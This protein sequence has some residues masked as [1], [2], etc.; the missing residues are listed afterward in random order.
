M[1]D[2]NQ[3]GIT[4]EENGAEET[5]KG[6]PVVTEEDEAN[7]AAF[8]MKKKAKDGTWV[9]AAP[10][11]ISGKNLEAAKVE[12]TVG[13]TS[14]L[15]PEM[16]KEE[17][18]DGET[19]ELEPESSGAAPTEELRQR[20]TVFENTD[21]DEADDDEEDAVPVKKRGMGKRIA[22]VVAGV[23]VVAVVAFSAY[24]YTYG[25]IFPG[26]KV[27][28]EYKLSGMTQSEAQAYIA[29]EVQD[30]VF[31]KSITLTGKD[32]VNDE[33]K[34]YEI[35]LSDVAEAV[36]SEASAEQAY[37]MGRE[38]GYFQR[39]STVLG[40]IFSGRDIS[41]NATLKDGAVENEVSEITED[42]TYDPT[43]PS[44]EVDKENKE[45]NIDT[46]KQGVG[47]DADQVISDM[48]AQAQNVVLDA[49]T[50]ETYAIDQDKPDAAAIAEDV[51]TEPQNATVDKE[52]GK[53][54]IE[55]VD[56]IEVAESDIAA[57]LGDA[58]EQ[59]YSIPIELTEATIKKA[60]LEKVLFQDTLASSTTYYNSGLSGRTT[61]VRLA[62]NAVDETILNPGEE[63]SYNDTVGERTAARGYRAATIFSDGEEVSG[64]GG[65]VCQVSS[66]IYMA[67]L[68]ADLEVTERYCHQFQVSY[69]PVSQDAAVYWGS[70]D[71]KFVNNT[72]YPVKIVTSVG[73]GS[74]TVS[75]IGT[76]TEDKEI[77]FSSKTYYS[78]NYKYATLYKSV[79]KNGETTTT[80]E[81]SSAY[82]L[83]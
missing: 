55:A 37:K 5:T 68:R 23:A 81:N 21:D 50:I 47:F 16:R 80:K 59:S 6:F 39:V 76:K 14:E 62:A 15:T 1:K 45:L 64:L 32:V 66:T 36:D 25:K 27:A 57:A 44:W 83:S 40:C 10:V 53:T 28:G 42:L 41:L 71:F 48:T 35:K 61:N 22:A 63:F 75:V 8:E 20:A 31:D 11:S 7:A 9:A 54:V 29:G 4:P 49:Y 26:V 34:T 60:D 3:P 19:E 38:G 17:P 67:I 77:S 82:L 58:S 73:G 46:G 2:N 13:E 52:D 72:D 18:E 30:N 70:K 33:E 51:N 43:Q 79:T 78:G 74:L 65:G 12:D 69:T 24:V 56:G